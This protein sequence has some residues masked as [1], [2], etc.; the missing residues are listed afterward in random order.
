MDAPLSMF[1]VKFSVSFIAEDASQSVISLDSPSPPS[2]PN[3][4]A[5]NSGVSAM[6]NSK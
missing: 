1:L 3:P 6:S 5:Y 4:P 2:T